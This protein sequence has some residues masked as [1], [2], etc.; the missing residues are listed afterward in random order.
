MDKIRYDFD[1]AIRQ[2]N[3]IRKLHEKVEQGINDVK[4]VQAKASQ[5][6]GKIMRLLVDAL[7]EQIRRGNRLCERLT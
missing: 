2:I 6:D 7:D 5:E 1:E 4:Q 3:Q